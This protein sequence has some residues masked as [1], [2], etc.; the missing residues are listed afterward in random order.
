MEIKRK[1]VEIITIEGH[2][3]EVDRIFQYCNRNGYFITRSG[4]KQ[5][6]IMKYD[7]DKFLVVA[8]REL[9]AS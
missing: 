5:I 1:K 4:P 6:D 8:E 2:Q 9:D 7:T 3:S